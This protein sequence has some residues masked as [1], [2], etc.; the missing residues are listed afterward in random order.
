MNIKSTII[1]T[2]LI[3]ASALSAPAFAQDNA[4]NQVLTGMVKQAFSAASNEIEIQI[5]KTI[6]TAGNMLS[7]NNEDAKGEVTITD[8]V[9][10]ETSKPAK[11]KVESNEE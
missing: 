7:L 4:V 5:D 2:T 11:Q 3:V 10:V 1:A 6:I 8:I 9:N